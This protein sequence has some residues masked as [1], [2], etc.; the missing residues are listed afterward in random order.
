MDV[1]NSLSEPHIPVRDKGRQTPCQSTPCASR[2]RLLHASATRQPKFPYGHHLLPPPHS[3]CMPDT[4]R[5]HR[6]QCP[7]SSGQLLVHTGQAS[8]C[9]HAGMHARALTLCL[10]ARAA[11]LQEASTSAAYFCSSCSLRTGSFKSRGC[12]EALGLQHTRTRASLYGGCVHVQVTLPVQ[13]G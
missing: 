3:R 9:A 4:H 6:H 10:P 8:T 13:R 12:Q 11:A 5:P 2:W 1:S 7:Q